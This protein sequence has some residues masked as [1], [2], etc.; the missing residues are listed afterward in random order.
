MPIATLIYNPLAGPATFHTAIN[1]IADSWRQRGWQVVVKPTQH[2]G[3]ATQLARVAAENAHHMVIAAGGDGTLGEVTNGLVESDTV[4]ALLPTGTGNSLAKEWR[5]PRP[6]LLNPTALLQASDCLA[7]GQIRKMDVGW[8]AGINKHWLLW[9][10]IGVDSHLVDQL[11]PRSKQIKR[12]GILGYMGQALLT[13]PTFP[14][15]KAT[16]QVDDQTFEDDYLTVV[17]SNCRRFAGG[18]VVLSPQAIMDDGLFE[19]WLFRGRSIADAVKAL[20]LVKTNKHLK[21]ADVQMVQGKNITI[22]TDPIMPFHT[23]GDP[24]GISPFT[25]QLKPQALRVLVPTTAPAGLF[26]QPLAKT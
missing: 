19:V 2:A 8:I 23:D 18:E 6:S 25:C 1:A 17:L 20:A 11:E 24:A 4:L 26:S 14:G 12:L 10:G 15:M 22:H 16:V 7:Q 21:S 3:H 13:L 5:M 9:A